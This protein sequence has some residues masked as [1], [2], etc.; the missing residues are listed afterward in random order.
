MALSTNQVAGLS[1][2]FDWRTMIDQLMAIE[3]RRVD[4]V[5]AKKTESE[6]KLTEW[7]SLNTK[8]LALKTSAGTLKDSE[9]FGVFKA[10]MT[11]N[12]STVQ[13]SDLLTVTPSTT[14]SVGS[15]TLTDISLATAQ[16]LSSGS[17]SSTSVALGAS[18]A[19][20][21]LINGTVVSVAETDTL[22]NVRDKINNANSGASP[23]GVTAGIV[24]YGTGDN[25]LILTSD[26]TGLTGIGLLNGGGT[27]IVNTFGFK[28]S[29]RS[30][31][32]HLAGGDRTDRFSSTSISIKSLLGL[33][34]TQTSGAGEIVINGQAVGAID[35]S[36]DTLTSL[37]TKLT[38]A[39][40]TA[41]ITEEIENNQKYYR[42]MVSGA[43]NTY[44]DKNNILETLGFIKG[45]VSDVYGVTGDIANTAGGAAIT[46]ATLIKDI[47]GYTGYVAGDYIHLEGTD[48]ASIP[49]SDDTLV[50][51]DT[52]TVG[53]LLTKIEAVFGDVTASI[54][55]EGK[56]M[57]VDN[58][59]GASPLA[60]MVGVKNAGGADDATLKFDANGDLGTAV[61]S[62]ERELVTGADASLMVD[63]VTVSRSTNTISD[64]IPGVTLNLLKTDPDTTVTLNIGRDVDA[65]MAK[66]NAFVASYNS[67]S[68]AIRQH[69]SYDETTK[70]PGG[71]LFGDGTLMS[72]KASLTSTLIQNV[73]GVSAE[74]STLGLVGV[75]V[76]KEGQL[77]VDSDTL[78]GY[79]TTNFND[80]Q[81]LFIADG[82]ADI[83]TLEYVGHSIKTQQDD[84]AVHIDTVA[85]RSTSAPSDN[86]SLLA[87]ETLTITSGSSVAVVSLTSSMTM[88]QMVNAVNSEL[89]T[90]YTQV[91]AGAEQLY[92]DSGQ[93]AEITVETKW[94]SVYN[95]IGASAGLFDEDVISFS[96]T[97]RDGDSV[98]GSYT[99]TSVADNSVQGLLTAIEE[100]FSNRVTAEINSSGRIVVTDKTSGTSNV[101]LSFNYEQAHDLNFGAVLTTN[102][103]G[104]TGRY[105]MDI[106]ASAD[107]GN[108]M[109]LTH[110]Q[111]G[112]GNDF[113]IHQNGNLLWTGGDQ[114]VNNGVDVSG[115]ING[116]AATGAGQVLTGNSG[117]AT[118]D[119]LV[120]KYTGDAVGDVG[121]L[122]LTFGVAEL[123][124]RALFSI[125]DAYEGYVAFKQD[126]LQ[127]QISNI[128]DQIEDMEELLARKQE[129]MVSKFVAMELTL[130]RMQN[131]SN[132]L[133][134]QIS[135]LYNGSYG[136]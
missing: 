53:D 106:T 84:H 50:L 77:S 41:S 60:V 13:A 105:A 59:T 68:S 103:G 36:T 46:S 64:I 97:N 42:L 124:D 129:Q 14:A 76:D 62:R 56:L 9:D 4:L 111:Y 99:I 27:D 69:T 112:T 12:S 102:T 51:S 79:L 15:Y 30:A 75:S 100:A 55:G 22:A 44:T 63:G 127:D 130:S 8:L 38:T 23:T 28:D 132:W 104:Q 80:V 125:T 3:R 78:R 123:F 109:V 119:G 54:T 135:A 5:T 1:S 92:A 95:S 91:L 39:G 122:T 85:T 96:G 21:L 113:T 121:T 6:S 18:Y 66:I 117:E 43:S 16:K 49:V 33:T 67:V 93:I 98:N 136:G 34:T 70:K 128:G 108:H 11:S 10:V 81:K 83:G 107:A 89:A 126:S 120:V 2:G 114:T 24:S 17:F 52:T 74:Y 35:L 116:E 40:L 29:S 118:I 94:N 115:T 57:I 110:D 37:Q 45:G 25:R 61:I 58:T 87:D 20:D 90:V 88:A 131:Q 86:T 47:D 71:I 19:G 31:K 133:A 73:W 32:N 134:G 26:T 48:T 72:V 82:I 65:I 101:A 7:Q